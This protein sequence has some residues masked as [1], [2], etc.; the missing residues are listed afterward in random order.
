MSF[1][2]PLLTF[3]G[4][5]ENDEDITASSQI[6]QHVSTRKPTIH[7]MATQP[8]PGYEIRIAF[9][10]VYED[11]VNIATHLQQNRA[12]LVHLYYL[13][14]STCKRLI[15]FLCGTAYAMSG[16]MKKVTDQIFL[17]APQN[18]LIEMAEDITDVEKATQ[19]YDGYRIEN[20]ANFS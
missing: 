13:D 8:Q 9:P 7:A 4:F 12:V 3:F 16:N 6:I 2:K 15:D 20:V 5:S 14:P 17:F 11:S 19:E 10:K 1:F 18:I